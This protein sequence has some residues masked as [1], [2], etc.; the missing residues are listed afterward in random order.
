MRGT[1]IRI[2]LPYA[3]FDCTL[4]FEKKN[5]SRHGLIHTRDVADIVI[6]KTRQER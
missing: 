4:R 5:H 2:P 1:L 3:S 6:T